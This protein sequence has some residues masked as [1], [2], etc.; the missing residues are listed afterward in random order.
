AGCAGSEVF[1]FL[2]KTLL[3]TCRKQGKT[4]LQREFYDAQEGAHGIS[5][6][7][8]VL[9]NGMIGD[10]SGPVPGG[11]DPSDLPRK[12]ELNDRLAAVQRG[13]P[14]RGRVYG[15][16]ACV[17]MS[18]VGCDFHGDNLT[19]GQSAY[20]ADMSTVRLDAVG[21]LGNITQM[22]PFMDVQH[23]HQ[24]ML[25][26]VGKYYTIAALLTNAHTTCYGCPTSTHFGMAPPT[27]EEYFNN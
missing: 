9:P 17:N 19:I 6:Q 4:E 13:R 12:S 11:S 1:G 21:Q 26:P 24:V 8:L 15:N 14:F 25:S 2:G 5:F 7:S 22:F 20:N 3:K 10:V 16:S 27:L 18:H 23:N